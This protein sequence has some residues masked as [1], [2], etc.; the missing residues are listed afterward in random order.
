MPR[1]LVERTYPDR[2]DIPL[3]TEGAQ[4]CQAIIAN[5]TLEDVTWLFSYIT[6]DKR[7]SICVCDAPAPEAI[8]RAAQRNDQPI[9]RITEVRV[10]EPYFSL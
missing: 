1:Y 8:R 5:D 3:T 7:K 6:T 10:F 2:F 4:A 9:D